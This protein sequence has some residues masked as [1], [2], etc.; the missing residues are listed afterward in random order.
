MSVSDT[1]GICTPSSDEAY[2]GER[3]LAGERAA[4]WVDGEQLTIEYAADTLAQYRV[5][6]GA[7]GRRLQAV[8][9]PRLFATGHASPQPF[10]PEL[11]AVE[12]HPAQRLA[13]YRPRRKRRDGGTQEPLLAPETDAATG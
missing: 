12:W 1:T 6:V 7:N 8:D 11:A 2:Y 13:P 5:T 3:G 10:L 4:V 9:E